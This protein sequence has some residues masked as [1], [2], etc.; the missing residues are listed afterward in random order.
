MIGE[1]M[2][3]ILVVVFVIVFVIVII[4]FVLCVVIHFHACGLFRCNNNNLNNHLCR[5]LSAFA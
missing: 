3:F 4:V 5:Q 1:K 2:C